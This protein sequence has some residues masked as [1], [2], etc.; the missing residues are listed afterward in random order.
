MDEHASLRTRLARKGILVRLMMHGIGTLYITVYIRFTLG[1]GWFHDN[2]NPD[3]V[4]SFCSSSFRSNTPAAVLK[5]ILRMYTVI[6]YSISVLKSSLEWHNLSVS[7]SD[8]MRG[9]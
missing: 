1:P 9:N 5:W 7:S 3:A 4:V 6:F 8:L 2:F